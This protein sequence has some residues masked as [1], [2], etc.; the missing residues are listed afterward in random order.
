VADTGDAVQDKT[1]VTTGQL[2]IPTTGQWMASMQVIHPNTYKATL[3]VLN[4]YFLSK[5]DDHCEQKL[6]N[7]MVL[8]KKQIM[9]SSS[10]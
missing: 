1:P 5:T 3:A 4:H 7:E 9:T 8:T 6:F 2:E 10:D